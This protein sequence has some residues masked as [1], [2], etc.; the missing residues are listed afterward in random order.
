MRTARLIYNPWSG[1][2]HQQAEIAALLELLRQS[3]LAVEAL[4]TEEPGAATQLARQASQENI[5]VVFA[6]GGDGTLREVAGGLLGSST[7]L[8]PL[9]GGTTNVITHALGLPAA[10]LAAA[11]VLVACE[12]WQMDV[13]LCA[14]VPFLMQASAGLDAEILHRVTPQAKR[15]WGKLAVAARGLERWWSYEYPQIEIEVDGRR[16][17]ASFVAICNLGQYAGQHQLVPGARCDDRRLDLLTFTGTGRRPTLSFAC[18]FYRGRHLRRPDVQVATVERVTI[19]GP[20]DISLQ[21]DGDA[22]SISPPAE[23]KLAEQ[24]LSILAPELEA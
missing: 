10:P 6:L 17:Q 9:P 21:L 12:P 4:A 20:N 7:T 16:Q 18:D 5:E 11:R 24:S 15:R 2:G 19:L 8:A 14:G 3:S 13:G 1:R 22:T 23:L